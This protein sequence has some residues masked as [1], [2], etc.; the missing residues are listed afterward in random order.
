MSNTKL[1]TQAVVTAPIHAWEQGVVVPAQDQLANEVPIEISYQ[2]VAHVVMLAT[3][4]HVRELALGFSVT[5]GLVRSLSEIKDIV[6]TES[7]DSI[8]VNLTV[9]AE[10]FAE[11]LTRQR[12]LSGRTGC[13]LCGAASLADAIRHPAPVEQPWQFEPEWV[14][15]ALREFSSYQPLNQHTGSIHAAAWVQ[16]PAGI[17]CAFEDVGRHNALDKL[18]G[19][20]LQTQAD[21]ARG[22]VLLSS[23][24]SFE[25]VQKS[26]MVGIPMVVAVSAPT[27]LAVKTAQALGLTLVGFARA[28]RQ[29]VYSHPERLRVGS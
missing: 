4:L 15:A 17:A 21:L 22:F 6:I 1:A 24:A 28:G 5:E 8:A 2:G 27:A 12:H 13:G 10:R 3:P 7:A 18:L 16:G 29:V 26:A 11:I 20:L 25:L 14:Q 9:T 23:R 19:H